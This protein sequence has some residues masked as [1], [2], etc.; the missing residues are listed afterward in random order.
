MLKIA[1]IQ[2]SRQTWHS[3]DTE[4]LPSLFEQDEA[5][6]YCCKRKLLR[7]ETNVL[8]LLKWMLFLEVFATI[9]GF[10]VYLLFNK[11]DSFLLYS[12]KASRI[13]RFYL[14]GN[15]IAILLFLRKILVIAVE[16]YQHYAPENVRRR[17]MFKPTCSEYTILSL[18]KHG[19]VIGLYKSWIRIFKKCNGNIYHRIDYP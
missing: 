10:S 12:F 14:L 19:V 18:Q 15:L 7:P 13:L 6:V 17:C 9:L 11:I 16:M 2:F 5:N 4:M 3:S 8:T 1:G